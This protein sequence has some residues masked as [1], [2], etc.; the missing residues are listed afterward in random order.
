MKQGVFLSLIFEFCKNAIGLKQDCWPVFFFFL[1]QVGAS[2]T[3]HPLQILVCLLALAHAAVPWI[4]SPHAL[5]AVAADPWLGMP[6]RPRG[7][8]ETLHMSSHWIRVNGGCR[9]K[10]LHRITSEKSPPPTLSEPE[11]K[12]G[13]CSSHTDFYTSMP[14]PLPILTSSFL[15]FVH[16]TC[17]LICHI[18]STDLINWRSRSCSHSSQEEFG[19]EWK[20]EG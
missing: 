2:V 11:H 14:F 3:R 8:P 7:S 1:V 20:G 5:W 17:N 16:F 4:I 19:F 10:G 13:G 18:I 15:I 6:G 12:R 9:E